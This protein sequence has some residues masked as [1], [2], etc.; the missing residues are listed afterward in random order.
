MG[1]ADCIALPLFT[2]LGG[3]A[4]IAFERNTDGG[5]PH[6]VVEQSRNLQQWQSLV[7]LDDN[8]VETGN[9]KESVV[10]GN[11]STNSGFFSIRVQVP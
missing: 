4:S 2:L 8:I 5:Q 3:R 11:A 6:Y 9:G 7:S 1:R 10:Y